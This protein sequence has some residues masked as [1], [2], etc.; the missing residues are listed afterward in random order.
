MTDNGLYVLKMR[1]L[2]EAH[3]YW[4]TAGGEKGSFGYYPHLKRKIDEQFYPI[5][6]DTQICGDLLMAATWLSNCDPINFPIE[7][8]HWLFGKEGNQFSS[9]LTVSDLE[10]CQKD[11]DRWK[12][13]KNR[14]KIDRFVVRSRCEI[15]EISRTNK[16][17]MLASLEYAYLE[18][19]NLEAWLYIG[20]FKTEDE[21][22]SVKTLLRESVKLLSGFGAFRSRGYGRGKIL[23]SEK[24]DKLESFVP[25]NGK[26]V[27]LPGTYLY[28][29]NSRTHFRNK[30]INPAR[31]QLLVSEMQI[32]PRQL[33]GWFSRI[34]KDMYNK[35]PTS[36]QMATLIYTTCYPA[37]QEKDKLTP[38]FPP[39]FSTLQFEDKTICDRFGRNDQPD[40]ID[41][42]AVGEKRQKCKP[43]PS[44][45]FLT[46][47]NPPRQ[48]VAKT[49][50]RFR[51][52]MDG[53]FVTSLNG[54]FTQELICQKT[55]FVGTVTIA[56]SSD[57]EFMEN[58]GWI[59]QNVWPKINGTFFLPIKNSPFASPETTEAKSAWVLTEPLAL[60]LD[61]LNWGSQYRLGVIKSYNT[62]LENKRPRRNRIVFLPGSI[63]TND[64]EKHAQVWLGAGQDI[65]EVKDT[66]LP[67]GLAVDHRTVTAPDLSSMHKTDDLKNMTRSQI[68]N[69]R[70]FQEM[71]CKQ[72]ET[73]ANGLLKKYDRW[74]QNFIAAHLIPRNVLEEIL[75]I[76]KNGKKDKLHERIDEIILNYA[77]HDW[78]DKQVVYAAELKDRKEKLKGGKA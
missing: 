76:S 58:A 14:L 53:S 4:F 77:R 45:V 70:A 43:L 46:N 54:L 1:L 10:L 3:G 12:N 22:N 23:F 13:D 47:E 40:E 42:V 27:L 38:A 15:E 17:G 51:N 37:L 29:I 69:L 35:W 48:V 32:S 26:P 62:T 36:E 59:L 20:Y 31:T 19:C 65:P 78:S 64:C 16:K 60:T 9:R 61:H 7:K 11:R 25:G 30:A 55:R 2:V 49:E 72:V 66:V 28:G 71:T 39:P 74:K 67:T 73:S 52:A 63:M 75:E 41:H 56:P 57:T 21:V 68:G 44:G 34:Y 50:K 5:Y 33:Q 8:V 6:P 24:D 18:G